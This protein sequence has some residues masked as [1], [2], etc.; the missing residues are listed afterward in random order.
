MIIINYKRHRTIRK[1][2]WLKSWKVCFLYLKC[3]FEYIFSAKIVLSAEQDYRARALLLIL[4]SFFKVRYKDNLNEILILLC[5][6]FENNTSFLNPLNNHNVFDGKRIIFK[7]SDAISAQHYFK[8]TLEKKN[9][10]FICTTHF[11]VSL[12]EI[13]YDIV[14]II[15]LNVSVIKRFCTLTICTWKKVG[16]VIAI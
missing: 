3:K 6:E 10:Y 16:C 9:T 5:K 7:T 1:S 2:F 12:G 14:E 15:S 4:N 11:F 13:C 8:K